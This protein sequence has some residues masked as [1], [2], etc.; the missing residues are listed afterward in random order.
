MLLHVV[1]QG[2]PP[3][4]VW[5]ALRKPHLPLLALFIWES[6]WIRIQFLDFS[7]VSS[8]IAAPESRSQSLLQENGAQPHHQICVIS[9][10]EGRSAQE[11]GE[12]GPEQGRAPSPA[13]KKFMFQ[14]TLSHCPSCSA[15]LPRDSHPHSTLMGFLRGQQNEAQSCKK[16]FKHQCS[17][18]C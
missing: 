15:Q 11:G 14:K 8:V 1:L 6:D 12:I 7:R 13:G 16:I 5:G 17:Y 3:H 9:P 18:I 4:R 2:P 10:A